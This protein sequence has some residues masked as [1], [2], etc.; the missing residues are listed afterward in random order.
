MTRPQL[1][2]QLVTGAAAMASLS[3]GSFTTC[4]SDVNGLAY[5]WESNPRGEMGTGTRD[6]NTTPQRV[7][8]AQQL[9][10][11]SAGIAQSCALTQSGAAYCWGDG[12]FGQLGVAPSAVRDRCDWQSLPCTLTPMAVV[13]EQR[14]IQ[15]STGFGS[16]VCAVAIEG[17]LYCWGL[18]TSGQ[19]GDG[20]SGDIVFTPTTVRRAVTP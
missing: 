1:T 8:F 20:S 11:V 17:D 15:I 2:P 16:H 5:C 4:A 10:Q 6:G 19:R 3:V 7:A 18:G 12:T 9:H 14:F 13:G